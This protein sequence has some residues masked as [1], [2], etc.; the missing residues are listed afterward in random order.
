ML[1]FTNSYILGDLTPSTQYSIRVTAI[2]L[3]GETLEGNSSVTVSANTL[4][5]GRDQG[6]HII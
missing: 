3:I 5:G 1:N 4:F 6:M 2:K